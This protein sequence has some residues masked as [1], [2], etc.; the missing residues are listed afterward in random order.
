M[1]HLSKKDQKMTEQDEQTTEQEPATPPETPSE[2]PQDAANAPEA[3]EPTPDDSSAVEEPLEEPAGGGDTFPREYV[4]RLRAES[5]ANRTRAKVLATELHDLRVEK[6]GLLAD[7][8]DLPYAD[9]LDT[10]EAVQAAAEEL[11]QRK[12]HLKA[13]RVAGNIGQHQQTDGPAPV[14][15]MGMMRANA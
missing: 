12:P 14:S 10:L 2:A 4:E 15:L 7:P 11:I 5:A 6:L 8:T 3:P 1:Y 13:R 9:G